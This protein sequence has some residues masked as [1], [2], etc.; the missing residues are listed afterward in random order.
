V[1]VSLSTLSFYCNR[2]TIIAILDLVTAIN[3]EFEAP[4]A[5]TDDSKV[6]VTNKEASDEPLPS[7]TDEEQQ[8]IKS[9]SC[10]SRQE[11]V[12][13]FDRDD[14][15]EPPK[16]EDTEFKEQHLSGQASTSTADDHEKTKNKDI[17]PSAS[18]KAGENQTSQSA[19]NA[20][21]SHVTTID[22]TV[23]ED[24]ND[25]GNATIAPKGEDSVV[26]GLLGKGKERVVFSVTLDMELAE[27]VLNLEDGQQLATL[28]Q[29]DLRA[30][31]KVTTKHTKS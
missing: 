29:N 22:P 25:Y 15:K 24:V 9:T 7:A 27:I 14:E 17:D 28:S 4:S 20:A 3:A 8:H 5:A 12:N 16:E 18:D 10:G 31:V 23:I 2:P 13:N 1:R 26:K 30:E 21:G 6:D 19:G 11:D